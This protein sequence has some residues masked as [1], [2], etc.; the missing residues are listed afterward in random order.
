MDFIAEHATLIV[1]LLWLST[2]LIIGIYVLDSML[3]DMRKHI[4]ECMYLLH[5]DLKKGKD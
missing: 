4:I 5:K 1:I 2:M 3:T